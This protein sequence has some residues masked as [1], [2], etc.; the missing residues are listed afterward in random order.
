MGKSIKGKELGKGFS[1][2]SDGR[3]EARAMYKGKA[4]HLYNT[5]LKALRE[6][7]EQ[8]KAEL[9]RDIDMKYKDITVDEWFEIWFEKYKKVVIRP[10]SWAP[11]RSRYINIF[12]PVIGDISLSN[13]R[14]IHIQ[15]AI[16][17]RLDR[18]Q[19]VHTIRSAIST[20]RECLGVAASNRIILVNPTTNISVPWSET[21]EKQIKFLDIESRKL[22][23]EEAD[24]SYYKELYHIMLCT[25]LRI[26][27]VG[28]LAWSDIDFKKKTL[29]VERSLS[30]QYYKGDKTMALT[31]PKTVN[32]Y[33]TIPFMGDVEVMLKD[34]KRKQD[35]VKKELGERWRLPNGF[36]DLVFTSS[37]GSPVTRYITEKD[38]K[39]ISAAVNAK[40]A[41]EGLP[42]IEP[43]FPH[44]LRHTF[45]SIC[46]ER[47]MKPKV[48]QQLMG[49]ASFSTTMNIY[50]H[51]TG[52]VMEE[53]S[54][55]FGDSII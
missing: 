18:G 33:R 34:W 55:L 44:M 11:L 4:I 25:G 47:N 46:F 12:K 54:Q 52:E 17:L 50:T 39:V 1:Q 37:M 48:V 38:L 28:G 43:V 6:E 32:S 21:T 27:E 42:G 15:D 20:L 9:E 26:G 24:N 3:Y 23:L 22:F 14:G 2:R 30:C 35:R 13:L 10:S 51:V 8:A 40:R 53:D 45:C 5:D 36:P 49:H 29:T 7:F 31:K 19:A 16:N 41:L